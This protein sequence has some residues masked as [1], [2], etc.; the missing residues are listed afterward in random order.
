MKISFSTLGC[1]NWKWN[2]ILSAAKD[3]GFDGIE[4]RG[5]GE[6]LFLPDMRLFAKEN[7]PETRAEIEALGLKVPCISTECFLNNPEVDFEEEIIAYLDLAKDIG[8]HCIRVM[9]DR[10]GE[11]P[12]YGIDISLIVQRLKRLVPEAEKA[13]VIILIETNGIFANS[14]TLKALLEG[15]GSEYVQALWDIH[16]PFRYL[17]ELP[18][19]TY[20]NIGRY[21]K[22]IHVKDSKIENGH[23]VYKMTGYGDLPLQAAF[24]V[25]KKNGYDGFIS[26]EWLK[27]WNSELED[28]GVVFSHFAYAAKQLIKNA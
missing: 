18:E 28:P 8:S 21:V 13:G 3:L 22:H 9:G 19:E 12:S 10:S 14:A 16:H 4:L 27:R 1:P 24:R 23:L 6:D 25:L 2:E 26:L 20:A 7:R 11:K 15:I 17:G 5:L